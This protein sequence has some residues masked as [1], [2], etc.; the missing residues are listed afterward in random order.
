MDVRIVDYGLLKDVTRLE[1]P[2]TSV[3]RLLFRGLGLLLIHYYAARDPR[4]PSL[5]FSRI[6]VISCRREQ[7]ENPSWQ[8][9]GTQRCHFGGS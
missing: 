4:L 8:R 1:V 2:E 6:C 5:S 9:R 3:P 7:R